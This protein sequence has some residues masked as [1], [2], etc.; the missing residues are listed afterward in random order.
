M[1]T[2]GA[3]Q[4][5]FRQWL[6]F[7]LFGI[8]AIIMR[9]AGCVINDLWDKNLDAQ[10]ERTKNRPLASG[11]ITF[12]QGLLFL[13]ALLL[14]GLLILLQLNTYTIALGFIA[15]PLIAL[16]PLMKRLTFW[17]QAFLG[18]AFNFSALMGWSAI[19][20]S[21]SLPAFLTYA[22]CMFWT[23]GYD[24][25]YAFQDKE[26]DILIGIK[27]TALLFDEQSKHWVMA[28]YAISWVSL[29][30][31]AFLPNYNILMPVFLLPASLHLVWQMWKWDLKDP[32]SALSIF[33]S[34][35]NYGLLVLIG[36]AFGSQF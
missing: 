34:N 10:V 25:V 17:P 22:S 7:A 12:K 32:L 18:I 15:I 16:Y 6:I 2:G 14:T 5:D 29:N 21:L 31:S 28:F 27:S 4:M 35:R 23:L 8:G 3:A 13:C 20:G 30:I 33:K 11:V 19:M 9:G 24:T 36:L 1:A 26:D